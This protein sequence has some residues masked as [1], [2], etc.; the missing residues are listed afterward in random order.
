MTLDIEL[1]KED[2]K[3]RLFETNRIE[4]FVLTYGKDFFGEIKIN[5]CQKTRYEQLVKMKFDSLLNTNWEIDL[6]LK[7][8]NDGYAKFY[9]W[10]CFYT[11]LTCRLIFFITF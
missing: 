1:L 5:E 6:Y 7:Y 9:V 11:K 4:C 10:F 8:F 3:L 2:F